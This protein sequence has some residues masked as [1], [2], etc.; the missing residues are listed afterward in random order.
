MS[1]KHSTAS[2]AHRR[3]TRSAY[4]EHMPAEFLQ[5]PA[6]PGTQEGHWKGFVPAG[7]FCDTVSGL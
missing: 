5:G 3:L 7:H 6:V 4:G 1:L 2:A